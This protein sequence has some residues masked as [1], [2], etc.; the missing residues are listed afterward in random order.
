MTSLKHLDLKSV[1]C[2]FPVKAK[3]PYI[4]I[5]ILEVLFFLFKG[6]RVSMNKLEAFK[7]PIVCEL[8][9]PI[10]T[11]NKSKKLIYIL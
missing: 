1:P 5:S 7:G 2:P 10:P 3:D 8:D 6:I 9:G 11:L 4:E